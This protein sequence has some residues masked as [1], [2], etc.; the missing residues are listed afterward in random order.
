[1][2][3]RTFITIAGVM[4]LVIACVH[5]LRLIYGWTAVIN[6]WAVPS[7]V[8]WIAVVVFSVLAYTAFRLKRSGR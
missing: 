7:V 2:T 3:Q 6:G 8:S 1:M 5:A 4:F